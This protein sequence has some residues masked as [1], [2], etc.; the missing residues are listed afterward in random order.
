MRLLV[1]TIFLAIIL[2]SCNS[3]SKKDFDLNQSERSLLNLYKPDDT[4]TFENSHQEINKMLVIGLDSSQ[5]KEG[6]WVMAK[7]A[8]N[9][10]WVSLKHL[11]P[12]TWKT[13]S[14][15]GT[16][17][18]TDTIISQELVTISKYPQS[19]EVSFTFSFKHFN[20]T[21]KEGLG[22]LHTDSIKIN[23]YS[24]TNY[25]LLKDKNPD[26][27]N[28]DVSELYWAQNKGLMAYRSYDGNYW[29]RTNGR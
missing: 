25:Y 24:L 9:S 6:G 14:Q 22:L 21:S 28:M 15:D 17:I 18:R 12:I 26:T 8:S 2:S 20:L 10:V 1:T 16:L 27:L 19:K 3:Y 7:P 23:G 4:L 5:K 13:F 11:Q 29:L